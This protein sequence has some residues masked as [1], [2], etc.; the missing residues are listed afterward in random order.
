MC[1]ACYTRLGADAGA[2]LAG[3]L[4]GSAAGMGGLPT[5]AA[6]KP[7]GIPTD[8]EE[9]VKKGID[10][11]VIGVGGFLVVGVIV[12]VL[13]SGALGGGTPVE[14]GGVNPTP[15]PGGGGLGGGSPKTGSTG[16][17]AP[18]IPTGPNNTIGPPPAANYKV[19][20]PPNPE[21]ATGTIG[22]QVDSGIAPVQAAGFARKAKSD[23]APNG[24]WT[25]IQIAVF[26]DPKAA[27]T[28]ARY[29][30]KRK[31]APLTDGDYSQLASEGV[32][33]GAPAFLDSVGKQDKTL[34]PSGNP[35]GW[36]P[37]S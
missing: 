31:G 37:R 14:E 7:V 6:G 9:P 10:P 17:V 19:V 24:K 29:Q 34:A 15:M 1:W 11:K 36:W 22:I 3:G 18:L 12:A 2:G 20:A 16:G 25:R 28:F 30:N 23:I 27:D 32:W 8:L 26:I 4:A 5:A 21:F 13:L 33:Q 35:L